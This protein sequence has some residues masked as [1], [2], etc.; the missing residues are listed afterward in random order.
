LFRGRGH[1]LTDADGVYRFRTIRPVPYP[2][3]TPHIHFKLKATCAA[4]LLTTQMYIAGEPRNASDFIYQAVPAEQR[5]RV[6]V[7]LR[8][9][10]PVILRGARRAVERATFDIVLGETPCAPAARGARS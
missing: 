6:T 2:G 9:A 3:R 10:R 1:T 5:G 4:N 7:R 8:K